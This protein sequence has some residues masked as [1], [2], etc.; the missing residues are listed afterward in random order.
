V[1]DT[2]YGYVVNKN[3]F[4][5]LVEARDVLPPNPRFVPLTEPGD[6]QERLFTLQANHCFDRIPFDSGP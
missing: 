5:E 3:G 6:E 1:G 4:G 2:S